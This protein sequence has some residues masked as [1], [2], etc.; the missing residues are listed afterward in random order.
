MQHE[1]LVLEKSVTVCPDADVDALIDRALSISGMDAAKALDVLFATH[2]L[3]TFAAARVDRRLAVI[4]SDYRVRLAKLLELPPACAQRSPEWYAMRNSM[5]TAS[6]FAQAVG[7]GKFGSRD[8][9]LVKKV[10]RDPTA[11]KPLDMDIPPL[12]WGTMYEDVAAAIYARKFGVRLHEFGLVKHPQHDF[13]GASPDAITENGIM[14][15]IKAPYRRKIDGEIPLQYYYQI[16]GQLE[17][18]DLEEC[19]YLECMLSEMRTVDS[20]ADERLARGNAFTGI[21]AELQHPPP[22]TRTYQ[23]SRITDSPAQQLAWFESV[24]TAAGNDSVTVV[25]HLWKLD[26]MFVCRV[27][28]DRKF[29]GALYEKLALVWKDIERYRADA[30]SYDRDFPPA[31]PSSSGCTTA[32]HQHKT[33]GYKNRSRLEDTVQKAFETFCFTQIRGADA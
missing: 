19:D 24:I 14:V 22:A 11:N 28:R 15:E 23:Y 6:D 7:K 1:H 10:G 17:V 2:P 12:R 33:A 20:W 25:R 13:L 18:C 8:E 31:S 5:I 29:W 30:E 27:R 16:Q 26:Q 32:H 9:L 21:V 4:T 3:E